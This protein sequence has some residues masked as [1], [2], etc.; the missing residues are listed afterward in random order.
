M[1][2]KETITLRTKEQRRLEVLTRVRAGEW[3]RT[4]AAHAL[5]LSARQVRR[6]LK[7]YRVRG[8]VALVH[9]NRGQAPVHKVPDA[10]RAQ[11]GGQPRPIRVGCEEP[12]IDDGIRRPFLPVE[13]RE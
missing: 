4:E 2:P 7:A 5:G 6:L 10:V 1:E 11:L 12:R 8:P 9:G 13:R 3:T